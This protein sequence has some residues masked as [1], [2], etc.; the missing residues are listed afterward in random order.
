MIILKL[1]LFPTHS[2]HGDS[3][4]LASLRRFI[5]RVL[6]SCEFQRKVVPAVA[7][8]SFDLFAAIL[9]FN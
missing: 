7:Q 6:S 3:N 8:R 2:D 1:G 5:F 4:S 9:S